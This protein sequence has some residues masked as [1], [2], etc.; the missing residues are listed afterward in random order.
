LKRLVFQTPTNGK[1]DGIEVKYTLEGKT[2]T[3]KGFRRTGWDD[4]EKWGEANYHRK[5]SISH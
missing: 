5:D 1:A 4:D 3:I 2:Y